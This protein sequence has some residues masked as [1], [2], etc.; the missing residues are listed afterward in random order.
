M[1]DNFWILQNE[2]FYFLFSSLP[3]EKD[4]VCP[5]TTVSNPS[6]MIFSRYRSLLDTKAKYPLPL[7]ITNFFLLY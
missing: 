7:R 2:D 4:I 5:L 3:V 6:S 1:S